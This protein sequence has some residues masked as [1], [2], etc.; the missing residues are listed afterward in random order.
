MQ[1]CD[2][3]LWPEGD[4]QMANGMAVFTAGPTLAASE[5]TV[6]TSAAR[7]AAILVCAVWFCM[8]SSFQ[9]M[10]TTPLCPVDIG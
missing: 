10:L 5:T 6:E 2:V 3:C 8:W 1:M 4:V 9:I 7:A